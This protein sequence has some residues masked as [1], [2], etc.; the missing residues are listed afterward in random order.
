MILLCG[1]LK[2]DLNIWGSCYIHKP[3]S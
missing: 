3:D 1:I 2:N